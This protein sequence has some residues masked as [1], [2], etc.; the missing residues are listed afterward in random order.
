M[1]ADIQGKINVLK[2][3]WK[4]QLQ[5]KLLYKSLWSSEISFT[6]DEVSN[7]F[8]HLAKEETLKVIIV[9][10]LLEGFLSFFSQAGIMPALMKHKSQIPVTAAAGYGFCQNAVCPYQ[11]FSVTFVHLYITERLW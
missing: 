8:N 6:L 2:S 5:I 4:H 9:G 7:L 11:V 3:G 10:R 1:F